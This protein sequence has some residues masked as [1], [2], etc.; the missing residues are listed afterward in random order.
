MK[1]FIDEARGVVVAKMSEEFDE[2]QPRKKSPT[3]HAVDYICG[4][5]NRYWDSQCAHPSWT[6]TP[7]DWFREVIAGCMKDEYCGKARCSGGDEFDEERG[8]SIARARAL[9]SFYWDVQRACFKIGEALDEMYNKTY[10][11]FKSAEE[12]EEY[13]EKILMENQ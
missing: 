9:S 1:Y 8:K 3:D 11:T 7:S 2:T 10:E 12:S 4:K 5:L 13:W 6:D